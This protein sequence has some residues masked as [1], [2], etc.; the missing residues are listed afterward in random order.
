MPQLL[1]WFV[2][3]AA[4]EAPIT[5]VTV[6]SDRARV[7]RTVTLST[8]GA[9]RI[10]LPTLPQSVDPRGIR[11][12]ATGAELKNVELTRLEDDA[13]PSDEA[14]K[15]IV[16][17]QQTDDELAKASGEA[18]A[19]NQQIA[20]FNRIAPMTPGGDPL[21]P[22]PKLNAAGWP[23]AMA[24]VADELAK[25]QLR[26]REVIVRQQQL[27]LKRNELAAKA[28][29]LGATQSRFGWKVVAQLAG[30]APTL[31]LTYFVERARWFPLYDLALNSDTG[32]VVVSFSGL[33]SQESGEDWSDAALTLSTAIPAT[34]TT[35]PKLL[36]WKIGEKERFIP[37]PTPVRDVVRPPPPVPPLPVPEREQELL[38]GKLLAIANGRFTTATGTATPDA[39]QAGDL[40]EG[41]MDRP[42]P[43]EAPRPM[44]SRPQAPPP[45][46]ERR[47]EQQRAPGSAVSADESVDVVSTSQSSR[48]GFF[49]R[50]EK[51]APPTFGF[52]LA[53]PPGYRAPS[54]SADLPAAAAGGY[55]LTYL[56]LQRET[57][58]SG[59][60]ARKVAL[61]TEA[62]PV[63]VERKLFPALF[64]EAFLVAELKNPSPQPLP[65]GTANLF[66][67]DD[68]A[69]TARLK[70]VSPGE[71]FT[72]PLGI[73]RALKPVR[74]VKVV[75]SET[76][77]VSK[78]EVSQYTVTIEVANPYRSAVAIRLIDQIPV[79]TQKD[80]E[81]KLIDN[82]PLAIQDQRTG[83]LEWRLSI[84][85][86][87]KTAVT[88]AYT[89]K[90]PKGWLLQQSEVNP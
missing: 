7:V 59:K 64:P 14:K 77:L 37:T 29:L 63:K 36:T 55:D 33:V 88:F 11:V 81:I 18:A 89:V 57:V 52:S 43:V 71:A 68:P 5:D 50:E 56:S 31:K 86:N 30:G 60:G 40:D 1:V 46:A 6:F 19:L 27:A 49:S 45:M 74:N 73:D 15:L 28:Q 39:L 13:L 69:G 23:A 10:E 72:L 16:A 80:V 17:L 78:D 38:R 90:R 82:K 32:K 62:W 83:A 22:A 61:F 12:E 21:K 48:G 85:A 9:Q 44:P 2:L 34:V 58:Q 79:T 4:V 24:F 54:Y 66:V 41:E 65:S 26:L 53:P 8:S 70:L 20:T 75:Q 87:Q 35:L 51:P 84:P 3:A 67:G 42:S 76:G 47:M 25:A